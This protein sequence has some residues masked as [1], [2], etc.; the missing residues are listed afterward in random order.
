MIRICC[1]AGN[2]KVFNFVVVHLIC[3]PANDAYKIGV[4]RTLKSRRIKKL[5]TGNPTELHIV[6]IYETEYPF[7]LEKMLHTHFVLKHILN[8]WYSL[9][10]K[11]IVDFSKT[12]E[13]CVE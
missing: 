11:D 1:A 6:H 8:E 7:R 5:Q 9:D 2:N 4:T 3:D 12:C 10:V 13:N